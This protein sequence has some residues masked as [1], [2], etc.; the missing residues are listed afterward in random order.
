M[1]KGPVER[2]AAFYL[3]KT[4]SQFLNQTTDLAHREFLFRC[5]YVPLYSLAVIRYG[6][7]YLGV[8][9]LLL[10]QYTAYNLAFERLL[11]EIIFVRKLHRI[12]KKDRPKKLTDFFIKPPGGYA[13]W[14]RRFEEWRASIIKSH[15]HFM[16]KQAPDIKGAAGRGGPGSGPVQVQLV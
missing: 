6:T 10:H 15:A 16:S 14:Q 2:A 7:V 11:L 5:V 1:A 13:V 4:K 8:P 9:P 12:K 3:L